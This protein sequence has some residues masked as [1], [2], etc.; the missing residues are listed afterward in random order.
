MYYLKFASKFLILKSS[1]PGTPGP[2]AYTFE[3]FKPFDVSEATGGGSLYFQGGGN[4]NVMDC[5]FERSK[6]INSNGGAIYVASASTNVLR[7]TILTVDDSKFL[8]ASAS[9]YGS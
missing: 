7:Q 5:T 3:A 6:A 1:P 2:F 4:N 9:Y 8:S